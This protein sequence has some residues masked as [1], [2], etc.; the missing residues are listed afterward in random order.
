M[1][2]IIWPAWVCHSWWCMWPWCT[3]VIRLITFF[4]YHWHCMGVVSLQLPERAHLSSAAH[5][6]RN[7]IYVTFTNFGSYVWKV[8][9]FCLFSAVSLSV[10][11]KTA[12]IRLLS[13]L[14][15]GTPRICNFILLLIAWVRSFSKLLHSV[16]FAEDKVLVFV[17]LCEKC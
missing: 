14:F 10:Y 1:P 4:A 8:R 7:S 11:Q 13:N 16:K 15:I 5:I 2:A 3:Y 12:K 9:V 6:L 17:I